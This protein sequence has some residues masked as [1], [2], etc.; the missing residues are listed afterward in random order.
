MKK[1]FALILALALL[2]PAAS[3]ANTEEELVGTWVGSSE[4]SYG[5]VNYFIVR[6]YDNH[7]ALYESSC[8]RLFDDDPFTNVCNAEWEL[9]EDGVHVYYKNWMDPDKKEA[10]LLELTQ[11][12]YLAM[13]LSTSY[14]MFVK[15]PERKPVGSFHTVS[16]WDD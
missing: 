8:I 10:L 9:D 1:I 6:L 3:L 2:L 14:V 4:F 15:L 12:H 13:R 7:T 11:A 5:E 16:N